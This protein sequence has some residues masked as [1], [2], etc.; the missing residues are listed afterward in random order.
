MLITASTCSAGGSGTLMETLTVGK[1]APSAA[2]ARFFFSPHMIPQSCA[3]GGATPSVRALCQ[4]AR[5]DNIQLF[6]RTKVLYFIFWVE[7]EEVQ[8]LQRVWKREY[9]RK[10]VCSGSETPAPVVNSRFPI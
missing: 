6:G 4:R 1:S 9:W 5:C 2:S 3:L 10:D 7:S 8:G